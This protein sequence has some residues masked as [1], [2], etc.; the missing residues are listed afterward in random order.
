ML[1]LRRY[2]GEDL[3]PCRGLWSELTE[4]HRTIYEDPTIGGSD[5]GKYFD[6]YLAKVGGEN[7]W[8][9]VRDGAVVGLA[10]LMGEGEEVEVEPVVVSAPHRGS[11]VGC[12]L[13]E[14]MVDEARKRG[15][16]YMSVR[17]VARNL[18]ALEFFAN[19]GFVNVGHIELFMD[20]TGGSWRS[21]IRLFD[22]DYSY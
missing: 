10:G 19:R 16:K 7:L 8:V 4:W 12:M 14:E 22:R 13:V 2:Q 6:E 17:P 5:P 21:G 20:L 11:G 15:V 18:K 3:V 1:E 9:A